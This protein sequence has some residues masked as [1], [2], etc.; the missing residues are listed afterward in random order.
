M[1]MAILGAGGIA[2]KMAATIKEMPEVEAYAVASR[3]LEKAEKFAEQHGFE[4]AYGSYE[5]MVKDEA[6]DLVYVATPHSHH[7]E[8][9]KLCARHGKN[10]LVEKAF[11]QNAGQAKELLELAKEKRVLAAEA[12]WTRYMPSRQMILDVMESGIIG[13]IHSLHATLSYPVAHVERIRRPELAG[14]ALLDLGVYPLNFAFMAFGDDVERIDASAALAET[15]VDMAVNMT[16]TYRDGK[17]ASLFCDARVAD[18]REGAIYGDKGYIM[19]QNI[20]NCEKIRV[21]D[22]NHELLKEIP[23]PVQISGYEYEVLACMEAI[24][25]GELECPQMPHKEIV[26]MME[27]MDEVRAK[28]GVACPN[29]K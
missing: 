28:I 25:K 19:V 14:G 29:E 6:V 13:E 20:N 18:N 11:T 4:K 5:E 3:S 7:L 24:Q 2:E 23:V 12:I 1:K 16:L 9:G 21:Y 15:G 22:H 27:V 26:R 17:V 8:H 10:M